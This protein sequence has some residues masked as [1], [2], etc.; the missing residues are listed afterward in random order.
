MLGGAQSTTL[1]AVLLL[2]QIEALEGIAIGDDEHRGAPGLRAMRDPV[3]VW[4]AENVL[5][6]PGDDVVADACCSGSFDHAAH[7]VAGGTERNGLARAAELAEM[8]IHER[9]GGTAG[10][11]VDIA[12]APG[13][14]PAP[15]RS[16][17]RRG[18]LPPWIAEDR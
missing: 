8:T 18:R 16:T 14:V 9:H 13:A 12:H 4:Q 6:L 2:E 1:I 11:R 15:R 3:A 17:H 7:G 10:E 5:R